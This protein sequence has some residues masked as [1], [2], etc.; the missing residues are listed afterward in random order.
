MTSVDGGH[1]VVCHACGELL[2]HI[3]RAHLN[4]HHLDLAAYRRR[5]GLLARTALTSPALAATRAEEGER[6]YVDNDGVRGGLQHGQRRTE[7][8]AAER[9]RRARELGFT[10]VGEYLR[11]RYVDQGHTVHD[12][13]REL[14]VGRR[15]L[16]R[17][18]DAAGVP[19]RRPGGPGRIAV[20]R[21]V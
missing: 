16:P 1:R 7:R 18:M 9:D 2:T 3:S 8:L 14:R 5:Y 11:V 20:S 12:I 19:R 10:S 21:G 13:G 15:V 17:L 4:T 6:R